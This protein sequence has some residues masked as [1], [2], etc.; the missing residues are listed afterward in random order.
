VDCIF[1][2]DGG[3][4]VALD[5]DDWGA[6]TVNSGSYPLIYYFESGDGRSI[7]GLGTAAADVFIATLGIT[8]AVCTEINEQLG[9]TTPVATDSTG[10]LVYGDGTAYSG[11]WSFC[12]QLTVGAD[13]PYAYIQAL[14][15]Q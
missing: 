5:S 11:E 14:A 7:D 3:E 9:L 4:A 2:S 12:V 8:E 10:D 1:A 13:T 6:V 15:A